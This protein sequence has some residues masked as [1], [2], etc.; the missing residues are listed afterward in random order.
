MVSHKVAMARILI[1]SESSMVIYAE[2]T[3]K[4][5][6]YVLVSGVPHHKLYLVIYIYMCVP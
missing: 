6:L 2:L 3:H 5:V 4:S 1:F